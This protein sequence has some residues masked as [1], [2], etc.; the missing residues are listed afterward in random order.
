[1]GLLKRKSK[2]IKEPKDLKL[3][4]GSKEEVLWQKILDLNVAAKAE[5]EEKIIF[6]SAVANLATR[7]IQEAK[8]AFQTT[9]IKDIKHPE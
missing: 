1:M 9:K 2:K 6:H 7:K 4:I 8:I 3:K 5:C